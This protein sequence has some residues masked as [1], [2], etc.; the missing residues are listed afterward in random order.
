MRIKKL[1]RK[2]AAADHKIILDRN[3]TFYKKTV[4]DQ[5][6][7]KEN[8]NHKLN[9]KL[10]LMCS[11]TI[12]IIAAVL[13]A[14]MLTSN[15]NSLPENNYLNENEVIR[16]ASLLEINDDLINCTLKINEDAQ[17]NRTLKYDSLSGDKLAYFLDMET[18]E[19]EFVHIIIKINK[20][21]N[22]NKG[23]SD[24]QDTV[25]NDLHVR[26]CE[27]YELTDDIYLFTVSGIIDTG[28][29]II[30]IDYE[31]YSFEACSNFKPFLQDLIQKK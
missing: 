14:I 30:F 22:F 27:T 17:C 13:C 8:S 4:K 21:Y 31:Q 24:H 6:A 25:I 16:E 1:L 19:F 7:V 23:I 20:D 26:Y 5:Y 18:E 28:K 12:V 11:I 10:V 15:D 9:I 2:Q 29:E 3:K